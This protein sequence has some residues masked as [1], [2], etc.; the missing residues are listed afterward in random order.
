MRHS[1]RY[2]DSI[3]AAGHAGVLKQVIASLL[4]ENLC[5][6][7]VGSD[8]QG[9]ESLSVSVSERYKARVQVIPVEVVQ[10]IDPCAQR[11][12]PQVYL[13]YELS[14]AFRVF[15]EVVLLLA[16]ALEV[17]QRVGLQVPTK[18]AA[19]LVKFSAMLS[20]YSIKFFGVHSCCFQEWG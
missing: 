19:H 2:G 17:R 7:N 13:P 8:L 5:I 14:R 9:E 11:Q 6:A 1:Q 10:E 12:E 20:M 18:K 3:I 15:D 16:I 4:I